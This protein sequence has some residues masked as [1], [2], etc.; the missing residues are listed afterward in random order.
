MTQLQFSI[1]SFYC[2]INIEDPG[3][4][5]PRLLLLCKEKYIK[6]TILIA[7]EGINGSISGTENNVNIV[8]NKI[9]SFLGGNIDLNIKINYCS[10]NPFDK[11][12]VKLKNEIIALG[13]GNI[14]VQSL[15]GQYIQASDWGDFISQPDCIVID[16][17]NDYETNIGAFKNAVVPNTNTFKQFPHW[18]HQHK[19]K[20]KGKKI[21]MYCTGGIRCVKSTSY[22][23]ALGFSQVYHLKGG[24]LQ[25]LA[26]TSNIRNL[27]QGNCFVFDNRIAV[28]SNLRPINNCSSVAMQIRHYYS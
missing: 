24:I 20:L 28:D 7:N 14:D 12:K 13:I 17:R 15:M 21:A 18:V 2:F 16:T 27:W 6:G 3:L 22:L 8:V 1:V 26:D 9:K 25:Y 10:Y 11:L 23:K 5:L 4:L 19:E